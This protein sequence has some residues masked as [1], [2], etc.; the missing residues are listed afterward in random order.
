MTTS[1]VLMTGPADLMLQSWL[2]SARQTCCSKFYACLA[3][4]AYNLQVHVP[5]DHAFLE[6]IQRVGR[7]MPLQGD[8]VL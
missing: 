7:Y 8:I 3:D 1:S 6:Q 4:T 2:Y 5:K